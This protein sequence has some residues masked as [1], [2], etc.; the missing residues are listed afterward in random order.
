MK[1]VD[2]GRARVVVN[3]E[4]VRDLIWLFTCREF[5]R[6]LV[7]ERG[8]SPEE[9]ERW[10]AESLV[11]TLLTTK[12]PDMSFQ[13]YIDNIEAK[14]G[15]TPADFRKAAKKAGVL[16]PELT[17]TEFVNWLAKD[18]D[19]GRGHAMALWKSFKDNGWLET[20]K[21]SAKR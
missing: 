14:T 12:E 16:K 10:L 8:W 1:K 4:K 20:A 21:K 15:H 11:R 19:L 3:R 17:A 2:R 18:F 5:Y 7:R 9:Y 13:A 6:M